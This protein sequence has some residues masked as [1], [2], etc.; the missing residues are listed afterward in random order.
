M[1]RRVTKNEEQVSPKVEQLKG[2][3]PS[4]SG[5]KMQ[6]SKFIQKKSWFGMTMQDAQKQEASRS[7]GSKSSEQG[8]SEMAGRAFMSEGATNQG[9]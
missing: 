7:I 3:Q 6:P 4:S 2:S 5:G 8:P 1:A 9:D